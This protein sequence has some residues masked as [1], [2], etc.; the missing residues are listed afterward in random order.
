R[1]YPAT[2]FL[3]RMVDRFHT[4]DGDLVLIL[5]I[6]FLCAAATEWIGIHAV[7]GAFIAGCMFKLVPLVKADTIHRLE[8]FVFAVLAPIFFGIVGLRV[9]LWQLP[10]LGVFGLV[11]AV[12][13]VGKLVGCTAGGVWGGMRFW[14]A[15]SIAVAMNARG[16]MGLVAATIGLSLGILNDASFAVIVMMAIVTWFIAPLGLR[17]TMRMVRMTEEEARRIELDK[18][19]GVFDPGKL[20]VLVPTAG[21]PNAL[22]AARLAFAL[23]RKSAS[24]VAVLFV[25]EEM[26]WWDRVRR[27]L[28]PTP[29][30]MSLDAHL[31]ELKKLGNGAP[32]PEA[33]R[34]N[35]R[36]A[37]DATLGEA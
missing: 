13:C 2:R 12:A 8:S 23:A 1:L 20:R 3:L 35:A 22:G 18:A 11:L 15:L 36:D 4:R 27:K 14:E 28:T 25:E 9:G 17:L 6:T 33:K 21:G 26:S 10:R 32:A 7:F 16:A 31:V 34:G 19:R 30:R 37:A 29:A 5:V 24:P